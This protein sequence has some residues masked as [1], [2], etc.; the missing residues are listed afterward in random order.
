MKF[1]KTRLLSLL[2]V[3]AML[4]A[5]ATTAFAGNEGSGESGGSEP[6]APTP[7]GIT[8][9]E[10]DVEGTVSGNVTL[11]YGETKNYVAVVTGSDGNPMTSA[12]VN[13]ELGTN[14]ST[15]LDLNN[16]TVTAKAITS[17]PVTLTATVADTQLSATVNISVTAKAITLP[18]GSTSVTAT[19][20]G[21]T[22]KQT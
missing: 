1:T 7:T 20:S 18:S 21:N 4:F 12:T 3:L 10:K 9:K 13:W 17:T 14:G 6:A 5:L 16:G 11:H 8:L 22:E 19:V 2:L 15:Y